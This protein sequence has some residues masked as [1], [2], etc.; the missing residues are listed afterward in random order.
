M[1]EP[2][3]QSYE[4]ENRDSAPLEV[5]PLPPA[6]PGTPPGETHEGPFIVESED[7][8]TKDRFGDAVDE[9][10]SRVRS[11]MKVV[12]ERSREAGDALATAAD[13]AQEKAREI[14]EE[15]RIR[16]E[17]IRRA[18]FE[19]VRQARA[20]A[21]RARNERPLQA[22]LVIGGAALVVG[23]LLRIWRSNSD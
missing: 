4:E 19:R 9:V 7:R 5:A 2:L 17:E 14:S 6:L 15:A 3:R 13:H 18:A 8:T 20:A 16:A 21:Q 1:A 22:L 12:A 23:L 10:R 11:G